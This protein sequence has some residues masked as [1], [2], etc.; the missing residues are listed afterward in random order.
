[1][2]RIALL[3]GGRSTEHEVSCLSAYEMYHQLL[4]LSYQVQM[5]GITKEGRFYLQQELASDGVALKITTSQE[6]EVTIK[7]GIGFLCEGVLLPFDIILPL[8]H[9]AHG[10]DGTL[11]GLLS[12][13]PIPFIGSDPGP[14]S[15]GM[16]KS[17]TKKFLKGSMIPMTDHLII[18]AETVIDTSEISSTIGL[19]LI[20]K[21]D[22]GGSSIGITRVRDIDG[23]IPAI[24][25]A[26]LYDHQ[27]LIEPLLD[28]QEIECGV[29][30]YKDSLRVTTPG[31][32]QP[33]DSFY[34]YEEKYHDTEL[35]YTIP[36]DIPERFIFQIR[37]YTEEVYQYLGC[38]G[39]ARVDF[40]IE[41]TS[42]RLY[43]NEIN[44]IPGLTQSSLFLKL[45]THSGI[46]FKEF[47]DTLIDDAEQI[48]KMRSNL[49]YT[50][51]KDRS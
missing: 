4:D 49:R 46:S 6:T 8:T 30:G 43:L 14:S 35:S 33:L 18:S 21:P 32:I 20:V 40:F 44:T 45:L 5:I 25:E 2:K 38:S 7:L 9:G 16:N 36:P 42:R 37:S 48:F 3:Y 24:K 17:M 27:V 51:D 29:F 47:I 26:L 22:A 23:I 31:S 10:E 11:Q 12:L 15:I 41:R 39:F 1:M 13:L 34:S 28:V 19:P 50:L